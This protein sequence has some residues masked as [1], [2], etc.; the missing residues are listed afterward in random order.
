LPSGFTAVL[1][2]N[3]EDVGAA[4]VDTV[5][6]KPAAE[7]NAPKELFVEVEF[8]EKFKGASCCGGFTDFPKMKGF[9]VSEFVLV[10]LVEPPRIEL[11]GGIIGVL[12]A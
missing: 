8:V 1:G 11:F 5:V 3:M 12:E 7:P 2:L 6:P 10:E 9:I 4:P